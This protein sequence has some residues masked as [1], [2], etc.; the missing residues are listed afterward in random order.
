VL[1]V[2][3]ILLFT[4]L[5]SY[6][7]VSHFAPPLFKDSPMKLT[8]ITY[9]KN[10]TRGETIYQHALPGRNVC[11]VLAL[12]RRVVAVIAATHDV[13]APISR[14]GT[15]DATRGHGHATAAMIR[16]SVHK[17]VRELQDHED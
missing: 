8:C 15:Q 1:G 12:A 13:D 9:Q 6:L 11:P 14:L 10:G 2:V 4:L 16:A 5:L 7:F 3:A 17:A